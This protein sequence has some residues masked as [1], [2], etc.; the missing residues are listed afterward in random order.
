[1]DI[2]R[3]AP[4][5]YEVWSLSIITRLCGMLV[6]SDTVIPKDGPFREI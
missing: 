2:D 4:A 3:G 1:M 6:M 5:I